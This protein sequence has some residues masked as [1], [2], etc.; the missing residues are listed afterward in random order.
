ME[1]RDE[2]PGDHLAIRRITLAAFEDAPFSDQREADIVDALRT[3][4]ALA[5]SL[6]AIEGDDAI[7]HVAFSPV[8]IASGENGWY[9]LGPVSVRPDKQGQGFG[10]AL[11]RAGLDRLAALD[12]AGCVLLGAPGYYGRFG[13]ESDPAL[14]Y[15]GAASPYL[16]RLVLSGPAP[17]G[18][19]GYHAA[20]TG[21]ERVRR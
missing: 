7:G 19:V 10:Q 5:V 21:G 3:A 8:A 1:I 12:A 14:T 17:R 2:G 16:Q 20:F 9:G 18:E 13:F 15:Q 11:V 4:G 6:V